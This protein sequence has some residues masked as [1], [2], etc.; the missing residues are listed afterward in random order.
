[1]ES[2]GLPPRFSTMRAESSQGPTL[3]TI[4]PETVLKPPWPSGTCRVTDPVQSERGAMVAGSGIR[5]WSKFVPE[6]VQPPTAGT[7]AAT[8][9]PAG[10]SRRTR[11]PPSAAGTVWPTPNR[12]RSRSTSTVNVPP[13]AAPMEARATLGQAAVRPHEGDAGIGQVVGVA[14]A[15]PQAVAGNRLDL[16][17]SC[18]RRDPSAAAPSGT[19]RCSR[20]FPEAGWSSW[21]ACGRR[22]RPPR[23]CRPAVGWRWR[24]RR[25][26]EC[27]ACCCRERSAPE[28]ARR[29]RP[30]RSW[31]A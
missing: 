11:A 16:S 7:C 12:E 28:L 15:D 24:R 19:R 5:T 2:S 26:R 22:S 29:R 9:S 20:P 21:R 13:Q 4:I 14:I 30:R 27:A 3:S 6:T 10:V 23:P 18:G 31:R 8:L 17:S 25:S 1:M